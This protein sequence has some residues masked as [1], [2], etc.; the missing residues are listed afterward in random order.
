MW[1]VPLYPV[2]QTSSYVCLVTCNQSWYVTKLQSKEKFQNAAPVA[3]LVTSA[4]KH[5]YLDV[6]LLS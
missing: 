1:L 3:A 4:E 5:V 6:V 2:L